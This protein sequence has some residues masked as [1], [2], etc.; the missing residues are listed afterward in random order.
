MDERQV[1][2]IKRSGS[3]SVIDG[4]THLFTRRHSQALDDALKLNGLA[5]EG[6]VRAV[7]SSRSHHVGPPVPQYGVG[8]RQRG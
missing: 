1:G 8:W 4:A 2:L 6:M 5:P 7:T 3:S